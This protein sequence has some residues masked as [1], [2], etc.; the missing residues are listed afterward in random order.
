MSEYQYY[1]FQA[2]DRPLTAREQAHAAFSRQ[3]QDLVLD[4][5]HSRLQRLAIEE[6]LLAPPGVLS[7]N[8]TR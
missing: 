5:R 6:V 8:R 3:H 4:L 2:I 1:E 7:L